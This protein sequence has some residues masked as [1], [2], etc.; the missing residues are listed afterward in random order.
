MLCYN[1]N[2]S[3]ILLTSDSWSNSPVVVFGVQKRLQKRGNVRRKFFR[4][5]LR[6]ETRRGRRHQTDEGDGHLHRAGGP[7]RR[8]EKLLWKVETNSRRKK[9]GKLPETR[10]RSSRLPINQ[11]TFFM[12]LATASLIHNRLFSLLFEVFKSDTNIRV[13]GFHQNHRLKGWIVSWRLK[14]SQ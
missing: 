3:Q 5:Q 12:R 7:S 11:T 1:L 10:C 13:W 14:C 2:Q 6:P 4:R 9:R 8:D